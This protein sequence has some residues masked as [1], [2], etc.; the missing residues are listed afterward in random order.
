MSL[1]TAGLEKLKTGDLLAGVP[2]A[3][4]AELLETIVSLDGIRLE[5]IVSKGQATPTGEWYDQP[6]HEFV[7]LAAGEALLQ[8]EGEP[9]AHRLCQGQW[10]MLPAHCR[11]RVECTLPKQDTIWLAVNWPVYSADRQKV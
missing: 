8:I 2:D 6:W 10:I 9:E 4:S 5:R 1:I 3:S 7:F 11:H